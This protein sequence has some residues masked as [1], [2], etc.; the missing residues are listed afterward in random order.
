MTKSPKN[1]VIVKAPKITTAWTTVCAT[2]AKSENE[3]VKS[4]EN[5]SAVMVLES[6]L[7]VR[8]IKAV[9]KS[10]GKVSAFVSVSHVEALPTW[11]KLR[12]LH[13]DFKALPL[14]KQLSTASAAYSLLGAGNGEKYPTL[15]ALTKEISTVRKAKNDAPKSEA[16][17]SKAKAPKNT[18]AEILAY[19]SAL[20]F[21][22]VSESD[23]DIIAEIHAVLEYKMTNA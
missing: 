3:I 16:K 23:A 17:E 14:A 7:S 21:V 11:S 1:A 22:S 20:D 19:V 4:V 9:I 5:L 2:S 13:A 12:A 18:L 15:E 8:D 6:R 10:S